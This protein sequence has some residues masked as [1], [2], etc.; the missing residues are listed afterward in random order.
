MQQ[1]QNFENLELTNPE[2]FAIL[3]RDMNELAD[4]RVADVKKGKKEKPDGSSG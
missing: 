3:L 4:L 2:S 1:S